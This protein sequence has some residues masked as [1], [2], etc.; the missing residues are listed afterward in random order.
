MVPEIRVLAMRT[1]A[2]RVMTKPALV[3]DKPRSTSMDGSVR[4]W[5]NWVNPAPK[6]TSIPVSSITPVYENN[7]SGPR[8]NGLCSLI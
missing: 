3:W 8:F 7:Q 1:I 5:A 2:V 4:L 6:L